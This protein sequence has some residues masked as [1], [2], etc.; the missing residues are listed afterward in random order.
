ML[1]YIA[2]AIAFMCKSQT[3]D[4]DLAKLLPILISLLWFV[5]EWRAS[6]PLITYTIAFL[7]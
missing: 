7:R 5:Y 1:P 4:E 3:L 6:E 2:L